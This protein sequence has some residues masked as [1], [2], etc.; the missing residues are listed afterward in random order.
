MGVQIVDGKENKRP[1]SVLIGAGVFT[2]FYLYGMA[3][4][5]MQPAQATP[6]AANMAWLVYLHWACTPLI[7]IGL[8]IGVGPARF[9]QLALLLG[10]LF[11]IFAISI[12]Y[13]TA[14]MGI[15]SVGILFTIAE[16]AALV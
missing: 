10:R 6:P 1:T 5:L 4:W 13:P 14:H 16:A 2:A 12:R 9:A 11:T 8:W 3:S 7:L 15:D